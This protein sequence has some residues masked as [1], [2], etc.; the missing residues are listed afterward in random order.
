MPTPL[1]K[2]ERLSRGFHLLGHSTKLRIAKYLIEYDEDKENPTVPTLIA[3][4]LDI[5]LSTV[6]YSLN[7]LH[8]AGVVNRE[9]SGRFVFYSIN[10]EFLTLLKDFFYEGE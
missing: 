2:L 3:T 10:Q 7:Q 9:V 6:S 1:E 5:R 4:N 8:Q